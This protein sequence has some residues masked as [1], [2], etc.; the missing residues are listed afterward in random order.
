MNSGK[1]CKTLIFVCTIGG[2][3]IWFYNSQNKKDSDEGSSLFS[4]SVKTK[5][6]CVPEVIVEKCTSVPAPTFDFV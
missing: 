3:S 1:I 2:I 6:K 5:E 4:T